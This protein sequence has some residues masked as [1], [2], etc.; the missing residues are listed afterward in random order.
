MVFAIFILFTIVFFIVLTNLEKKQKQK[1][2]EIISKNGK[3]KDSSKNTKSNPMGDSDSKFIDPLFND[4]KNDFGRRERKAFKY[5]NINPYGFEKITKNSPSDIPQNFILPGKL[6]FIKHNKGNISKVMCPKGFHFQARNTFTSASC[7][8]NLKYC[9]KYDSKLGNCLQCHDFYN[10]TVDY[11]N[12]THY[13]S[14]GT[15]W[16]F[17]SFGLIILVIVIHYSCV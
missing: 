11:F 4:K 2:A 1:N 9:K 6:A 14:L 3:G 17:L 16:T 8:Y 12:K 15:M 13:C 10:I 7:V 5:D